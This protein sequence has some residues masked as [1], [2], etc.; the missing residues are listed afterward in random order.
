MDEEAEQCMVNYGF[1]FTNDGLNELLL[2][3]MKPWDDDARV[4][5]DLALRSTY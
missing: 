4:C 5:F 1:K 2:Q 3:G